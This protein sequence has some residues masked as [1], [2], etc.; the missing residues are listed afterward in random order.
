VT[1]LD[2]GDGGR[3]QAKR[4][5]GECRLSVGYSGGTCGGTSATD[6]VKPHCCRHNVYNSCSSVCGVSATEGV[7]W[8]E[9]SCCW[10]R[11]RHLQMC[12]AYLDAHGRTSVAVR[13]QP[14]VQSL[15][16]LA[17]QISH[18]AELVVSWMLAACRERLYFGDSDECK[19]CKKRSCEIP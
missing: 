13:A 18:A 6:L 9:E 8:G 7:I 5:L 11:R 14:F 15:Y 19:S 3:G 1:G 17:H 4:S 10:V 12:H 2:A 16:H